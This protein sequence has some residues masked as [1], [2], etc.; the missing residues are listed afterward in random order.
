MR[1][2]G[3]SV[4]GL[5][6]VRFGALS[7]LFSAHIGYAQQVHNVVLE[8]AQPPLLNAHAGDSPALGS[9]QMVLGGNPAASGGVGPYQFEWNPELYLSNYQEANPTLIATADVDVDY[10]LTVTDSRDCTA[11]DTVNVSVAIMGLDDS[12]P[13]FS[14]YPNPADDILTIQ[15]DNEIREIVLKDANGRVVLMKDQ[16]ETRHEINISELSTGVYLLSFRV[17]NKLFVRK[18]VVGRD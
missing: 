10:I 7:L 3:F 8:I 4:K 6:I 9:G 12:H 5:R 2:Q 18:V 14:L 17:Q 15:G 11:K 1:F 13:M 16:A